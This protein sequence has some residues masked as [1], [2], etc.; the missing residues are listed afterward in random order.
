MA[1][2]LDSTGADGKTDS[3]LPLLPQALKKY[4]PPVKASDPEM[5]IFDR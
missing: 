1:T 5:M 2:R 3:A 4:S